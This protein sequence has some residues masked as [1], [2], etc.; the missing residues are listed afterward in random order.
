MKQSEKEGCQWQGNQKG[1]GALTASLYSSGSGMKYNKY[2][3]LFIH[4]FN[5]LQN[6]F[7]PLNIKTK[8]AFINTVFSRIP[9]AEN[10]VPC[11]PTSRDLYQYSFVRLMMMVM[12][13]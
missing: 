9:Q 6:L 13:L 10:E 1:S 4:S 11:A 8:P 2:T 5:D 12:S 7:F 3:H